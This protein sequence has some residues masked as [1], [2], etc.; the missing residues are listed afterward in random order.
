MPLKVNS[1]LRKT[2][3]ASCKWRD[4][5]RSMRNRQFIGYTLGPLERNFLTSL[6]DLKGGGGEEGL[7]NF[8]WTDYLFS[9][10]ALP[11]NLFS[12]GI[13]LDRKIYKYGKPH[14]RQLLET[15]MLLKV[16]PS[17]MWNF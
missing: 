15:V 14:S 16:V 2:F 9:A 10:K 7:S 8:S 4:P 5:Q 13:G 11:E 3:Q 6:G 1:C 17:I 12:C